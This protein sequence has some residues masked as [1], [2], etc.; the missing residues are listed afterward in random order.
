[1]ACVLEF[2]PSPFRVRPPA[3]VSSSGSAEVVLFPGVRYERLPEEAA[4][5]KPR[6]RIHRRDRLDL[7]D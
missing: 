1:M 2:R 4:A 6:R 3:V 5:S 7:D